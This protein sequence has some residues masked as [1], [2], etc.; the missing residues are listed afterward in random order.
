LALEQD[1]EEIGI[2]CVQRCQDELEVDLLTTANR[3]TGPET[4]A[5]VTTLASHLGTAV[6]YLTVTQKH[7]D[8]LD[9]T[10]AFEFERAREQERHF[11]YWIVEDY[12]AKHARRRN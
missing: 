6:R 2:A 4:A 8:V 11:V 1:G 3:W 9:E 5:L 12:F 7:A 10:P